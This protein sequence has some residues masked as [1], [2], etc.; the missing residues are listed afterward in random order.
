MQLSK[1]EEMQKKKIRPGKNG[2]N[3]KEDLPVE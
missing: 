2:L 3:L 1:T